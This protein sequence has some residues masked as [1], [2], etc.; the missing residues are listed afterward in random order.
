VGTKRG[1][2]L[3]A[4]ITAVERTVSNARRAFIATSRLCHRRRI[5]RITHPA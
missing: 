5:L 2:G 3:A 4:A 1:I